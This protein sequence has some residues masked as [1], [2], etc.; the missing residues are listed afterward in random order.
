MKGLSIR[1]QNAPG[2]ADLILEL[3][4]NDVDT[5]QTVTLPQDSKGTY[6]DFSAPVAVSAGDVVQ[7]KPTQHGGARYLTVQAKVQL[8]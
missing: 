8:V 7:F 1:A 5:G 6:A 3:V 2:S 4:V